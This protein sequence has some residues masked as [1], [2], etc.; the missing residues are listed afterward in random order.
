MC[1][2]LLGVPG[3]VTKGDRGKGGSKLTKNSLTYFMDGPLP[4]IQEFSYFYIF[5]KDGASAHRAQD[6]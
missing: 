3:Y 2:V 4:E 6:E 1:D 5:Q